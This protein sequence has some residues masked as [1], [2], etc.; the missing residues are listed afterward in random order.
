MINTHVLG[1]LITGIV[2]IIIAHGILSGDSFPLEKLNLTR[3]RDAFQIL[4]DTHQ[5]SLA[6]LTAV[7]GIGQQRV[8]AVSQR[9]EMLR[10]QPPCMEVIQLYQIGRRAVFAIVTDRHHRKERIVFFQS[11]QIYRSIQEN[12]SQKIPFRRHLQILFFQIRHVIR[13]ACYHTQPIA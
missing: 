1:Q 6:G 11:T 4:L 7:H 13:I 3:F 5:T 8:A 9:I 2:V 12:G 10:S